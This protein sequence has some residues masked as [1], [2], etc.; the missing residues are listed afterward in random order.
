MVT[1]IISGV[2]NSRVLKNLNDI[3]TVKKLKD[4]DAHHNGFPIKVEVIFMQGDLTVRQG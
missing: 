1:I 2:P 3:V 4:T